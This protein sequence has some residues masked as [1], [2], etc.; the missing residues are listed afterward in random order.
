MSQEERKIDKSNIDPELE[1]LFEATSNLVVPPSKKGKQAV[2]DN[3]VQ[4]IDQE[5]VKEATVI[6]FSY[7]KIFYSIAAVIIVF[8]TIA[9]LTYRFA[10]VE[11]FSPKGEVA[12][13]ILPDGSELNLNADTKVEYRK[14]GWLSDRVVTLS[15]EA[16]FKVKSG[17]SFTVLAGIDR[18]VTV[19]GTEFNVNARESLF[20]VKCYKGSVLVETPMK[21]KIP[22]TK[23]NGISVKQSEVKPLQFD[24]DSISTP[25]WIKGEFFFENVSLNEV[26]GELSRQF[27]VIINAEGFDPKSRAY[28]GYFQRTKLEQALDLV[29]LPMGL[30]Y[31]VSTDNKSV[32]IIFENR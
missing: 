27:N 26:F 23:G 21:S 22:I 1:K 9:T 31:T 29:C 7:A 24:V 11:V 5:D 32:N 3:I 28:T 6:N 18:K 16:F 10:R 2:W 25:A 12:S 8:L 13:T 30:K 19:T 20:E 15:G 4:A 17:N 14:Y